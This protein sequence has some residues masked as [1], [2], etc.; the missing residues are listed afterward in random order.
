MVPY[1][2]TWTLPMKIKT[3]FR[4]IS[5]V[6]ALVGLITVVLGTLLV[7]KQAKR[8]YEEHQSLV[9]S[10]EILETQVR[11]LRCTKEVVEEHRKRAQKYRA[12]GGSVTLMTDCGTF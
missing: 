1:P 8:V 5:T 3:L 12:H 4:F 7:A 10:V 2:R 6:L 9:R 11:S